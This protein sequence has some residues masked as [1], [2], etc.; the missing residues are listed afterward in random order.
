MYLFTLYTDLS[1]V[2]KLCNLSM[3]RANIKQSLIECV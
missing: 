2:F 3:Y 1:K